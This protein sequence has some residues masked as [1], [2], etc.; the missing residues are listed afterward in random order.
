MASLEVTKQAEADVEDVLLRTLGRWG[1]SK[2]WD[3]SE[4]IEEAY[5]AIAANPKSGRNCSGVRPGILRHH[6]KRPGRNARHVVFYVY[7]A[8]SDRVTVVRV[9]H[10]SMD[11]NQHLP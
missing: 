2:Y 7:D 9:L 6:I 1:A 4:L 11:F 10:D 3:Y 8:T 5:A